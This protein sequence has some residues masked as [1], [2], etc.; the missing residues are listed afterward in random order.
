[1]KDG[2]VFEVRRAAVFVCADSSRCVMK[3]RCAPLFRTRV[4]SAQRSFPTRGVDKEMCGSQLW[5][6]LCV[7][8]RLVN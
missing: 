2:C 4:T 8:L 6:A 5:E 7:T 3:F 1:M